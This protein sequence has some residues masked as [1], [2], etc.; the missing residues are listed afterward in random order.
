MGNAGLVAAASLGAF[1]R[2]GVT[3]TESRPGSGLMRAAALGLGRSTSLTTPGAADAA[4]NGDASR[5]AGTAG[6]GTCDA[7]A[8]A[9]QSGGDSVTSEAEGAT[10]S[11]VTLRA[12]M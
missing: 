1:C 9:V 2:S 11:E 3:G 6:D 8:V 7:T 10:E 12:G 5:A 4:R